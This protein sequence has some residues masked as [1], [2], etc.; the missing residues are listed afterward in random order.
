MNY[1]TNR[2]YQTGYGE[3]MLSLREFDII[4]LSGKKIRKLMFFD[5]I[6]KEHYQL[7]GLP[8]KLTGNVQYM[9][10]KSGHHRDFTLRKRDVKCDYCEESEYKEKS[11]QV[12]LRKAGAIARKTKQPHISPIELISI[13]VNAMEYTF[14]NYSKIETEIDNSFSA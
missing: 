13:L 6:F 5:A 9:L 8:F 12:F 1:K 14:E 2:E 11:H 3:F 4:D 7:S 10:L